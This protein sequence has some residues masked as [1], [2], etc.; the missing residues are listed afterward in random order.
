LQKDLGEVIS[1]A[2]VRPKTPV[3]PPVLIAPE[4]EQPFVSPLKKQ[5]ERERKRQNAF[6]RF[7]LV[8][9]LLIAI[10]IPILAPALV[11]DFRRFIPFLAP[12]ATPTQMPSPTTTEILPLPTSTVVAA[13]VETI[14]SPTAT[15][16][17]TRSPTETN[18]PLPIV[19]ETLIPTLTAT[20]TTTSI[21]QNT[22]ASGPTPMGGGTGQI[23]FASTQSGIPQIYLMDVAGNEPL[24]LTN[25]PEGAC[26][27]AWSPDGARMVFVSPCKGI[28]DIYFNG[29][30]YLINA[31]GSELTPII[32][33]P[34]G[35]FEPDWS[36]DGTQIAFTSLRTGQMEIFVYNLEDQSVTQLTNRTIG[37]ASRQA[38]WSPDGT[39]IA[40]VV[41][42][43]GV[44]QIWLMSATGEDQ[45]QIVRSGT[46]LRDHQ[47]TWSPDGK[48]ILFIQRRTDTPSLPYL[49]SINAVDPPD[50][51]G[52]RV[53]LNTLPV[54][55]AEFSPDGFWIIFEGNNRDIFY[56][57]Y[58]GGS[59]AQIETGKG[60]AFDPTWRPLK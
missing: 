21:P 11:T 10:G 18:T 52:D 54:E 44:R 49:M 38:A 31:D 50:E 32:S 29:T 30:L 2:E 14:I 55:D 4:E 26:Q 33:V 7:V 45:H 43:L 34:G 25:M 40:Y 39:Q 53:P 3:P 46:R 35:D 27:P 22:T 23:A 20:A 15:A 28:D 12:P 5:K 60:A 9:L 8:L 17:V 58:T 42:R 51:Q 1:D 16:T 47:P 19:T 48:S 57:V 6:L 41:Q 36:P 59:D 24:Q 37:E 56:V 13:L